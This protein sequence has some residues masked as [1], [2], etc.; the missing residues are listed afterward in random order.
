MPNKMLS[1]TIIIRRQIYRMIGLVILFVIIAVGV[2]SWFNSETKHHH[3]LANEY[4]LASMTHYLRASDELDNIFISPLSDSEKLD[5]P[6]ESHQ[7][8]NQTSIYIVQREIRAGNKLQDI[9]TKSEFDFLGN[10][11]K[12]KLSILIE[13]TK[14]PS[15]SFS[16]GVQIIGNLSSIEK[17]LNQLVRLHSIRRETVMSEITHHEKRQSYILVALAIALLVTAML[18]TRRGLTAI[19]SALEEREQYDEE[20]KEIEQQLRQARKMDAIGQLTGGIAHDY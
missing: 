14:N 20:R 3:Q 6:G 9:F 7:P 16:S 17:T 12:K 10:E 13:Y 18:I 5:N 2:Y 4:H 8:N 15:S 11:L 1:W 19:R